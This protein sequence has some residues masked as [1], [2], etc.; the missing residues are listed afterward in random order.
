MCGGLSHIPNKLIHFCQAADRTHVQ[1]GGKTSASNKT[2]E[3]C[4]VTSITLFFFLKQK[5]EVYIFLLL[6][7]D[8]FRKPHTLSTD[9]PSP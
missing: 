7:S 8:L 2:E 6:Y 9:R 5:S 4:S 3:L 1:P